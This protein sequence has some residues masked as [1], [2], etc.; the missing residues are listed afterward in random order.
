M[1]LMPRVGGYFTVFES[2]LWALRGSLN[3]FVGMLMVSV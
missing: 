2:C 1:F 3:G